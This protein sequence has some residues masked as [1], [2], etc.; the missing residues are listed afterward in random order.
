MRAKKMR[1]KGS[2]KQF[3]KG[4]VCKKQG[5]RHTLSVYNSELYCHVHLIENLG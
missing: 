3:P 1:K 2:L 4:R 5:C